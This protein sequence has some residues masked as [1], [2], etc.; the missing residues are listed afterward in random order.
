MKAISFDDASGTLHNYLETDDAY[1]IDVTVLKQTG[2]ELSLLPTDGICSF[3]CWST[4]I[5]GQY[6]QQHQRSTKVTSST[7]RRKCREMF[8]KIVGHQQS[9]FLAEATSEDGTFG[10]ISD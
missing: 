5:Q 10:D 9:N 3:H 4:I 6:S 8:D 7:L 1:Y 2:L